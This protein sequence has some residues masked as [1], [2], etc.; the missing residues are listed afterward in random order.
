MQVKMED[1]MK[2]SSHSNLSSVML[3][4]EGSGH[5]GGGGGEGAELLL[6]AKQFSLHGLHVFRGNLNKQDI[7]Q[8]FLLSMVQ[9][10][11]EVARVLS[12]LAVKEGGWGR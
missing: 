12:L 6:G 1:K 2:F 8:N 5:D 7:L 3:L 10:L 4:P 9:S 11:V